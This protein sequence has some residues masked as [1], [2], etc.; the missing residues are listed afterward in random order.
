MPVK[1]SRRKITHHVA[2]SLSTG[3][4]SSQIITQLAGFLV[5]TGRT[6]ELDII[7][8]DIEYSLAEQGIVSARAVTAFDLS[9]E[10]RREIEA[11][12]NNRKK[13]HDIQLQHVVDPDVLGGVKLDIPGFRLD[14]TL[15]HKL[16]TLRTNYKK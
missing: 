2:I 10:T 16:S 15:A 11:I 14:T 12:I 7:V 6:K 3:N 13:S 1:L 9:V 8:R 4:N 5:D